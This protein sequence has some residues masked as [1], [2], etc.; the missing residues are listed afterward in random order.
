VY[1]GGS[2]TGNETPTRENATA[3][4][5]ST[6]SARSSRKSRYPSAGNRR[7]RPGH[8]MTA[9]VLLVTCRGQA[10]TRPP[11]TGSWDPFDVSPG[12]T[13]W[14]NGLLPDPV[15]VLQG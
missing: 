11:A 5:A 7:A 4:G 6:R 8:G 3:P 1:A 9:S 15:Q 2:R 14:A 10:W 13:S 12:I